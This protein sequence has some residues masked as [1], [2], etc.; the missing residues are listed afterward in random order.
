ME[1]ELRC[2]RCN[3]APLPEDLLPIESDNATYY[4]CSACLKQAEGTLAMKI[5]KNKEER[6]LLKNIRKFLKHEEKN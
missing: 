3:S 6:K 5:F 1:M 4:F 2:S